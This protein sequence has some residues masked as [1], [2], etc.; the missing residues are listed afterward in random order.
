MCK[1]PR[2]NKVDHYN[3]LY[4]TQDFKSWLKFFFSHPG[5][6]NLI[7]LFYQHCSPET[8]IMNDIW[9][10]PA[11]HSM[12]LFITTAENLTFSFFID[13]FNPFMN[14]TTGKMIS[15]G[16]IIMFCLNLPY[17]LHHKPQN[18]FFARITS[19]PHKL[20][21]TTITTL[22]DPI[23]DQLHH[24]HHGVIVHTYCYPE[25]II[26]CIGILVLIGDLPAIRKALGFARIASFHHFC[27]FCSLGRSDIESLDVD[28]WRPQ[29]GLEVI[30]AAEEWK[31]VLT[32]KRCTELFKRNN[33]Q[34]SSLHQLSYQDPVKHTVLGI[35]HNWL[36]GILQYH[37]CVK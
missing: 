16:A 21:V 22:L 9:D 34:W 27:S 8:M 18:T 26:K 15:C 33:M 37:V 14:K 35:M 11:W 12:G 5:I 3:Q 23:I 31:Q 30:A 4:T 32:K 7:D 6:E 20:S 19:L 10:S 24:F 25:G 13:W 36:E 29:I 1:T 17:H 28:L 2:D